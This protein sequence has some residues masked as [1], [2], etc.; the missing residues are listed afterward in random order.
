MTRLQDL[1]DAH[2]HALLAFWEA[3]ELWVRRNPYLYAGLLVLGV[4]VCLL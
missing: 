4:A 3:P 2:D 1:E